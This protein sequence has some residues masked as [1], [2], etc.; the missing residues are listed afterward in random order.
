MQCLLLTG[1]L[2]SMSDDSGHLEFPIAKKNTFF[3]GHPMIICQKNEFYKAGGLL[4]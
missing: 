4:Q 1:L 3:S 2:V